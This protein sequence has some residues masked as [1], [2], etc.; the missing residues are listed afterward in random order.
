[1][2]KLRLEQALALFDGVVSRRLF[3][4]LRDGAISRRPVC[5][6]RAFNASAYSGFGNNSPS[7]STSLSHGRMIVLSV[8]SA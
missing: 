3:Q 6:Y 4:A 8:A 7:I 1:V 2:V 5:R